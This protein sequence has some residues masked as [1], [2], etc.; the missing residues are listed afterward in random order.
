MDLYIALGR[1]VAASRKRLGL[2]QADLAAQ[3]SLTRASVAN[4]ET[5]RQR[6]MLH[7]VFALVEALGGKSIL[8]FVPERVP[9]AI[10][11]DVAFAGDGASKEDERAMLQMIE[12]ATAA[13]R[14]RAK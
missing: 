12:L 3:I 9:R 14:R 6:V 5:G 4:I 13:P 2:T 10:V 1:K 7:D 11:K 8:D